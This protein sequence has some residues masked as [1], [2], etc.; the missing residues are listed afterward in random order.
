MSEKSMLE[1]MSEVR[2]EAL[3]HQSPEAALA[4]QRLTS[5]ETD[6]DMDTSLAIANLALEQPERFR[7]LVGFLP[8]PIQDIFFQSDLLG[9]T[10]AHIGRLLAWN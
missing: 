6:P 7:E 1:L 9:R 4:G 8:L 5:A 3:W 2:A 10:Q